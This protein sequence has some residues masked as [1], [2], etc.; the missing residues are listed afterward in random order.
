MVKHI[1]GQA[2][3]QSVVILTVLFGGTGFISEQFCYIGSPYTAED[4]G[5]DYCSDATREALTFTEIAEKLLAD[6][7]DYY[8]ELK[9]EWDKGNFNVLLGMQ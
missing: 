9:S 2:V 5:G 6:N 4:V 1:L 8:N 3:F 7:P